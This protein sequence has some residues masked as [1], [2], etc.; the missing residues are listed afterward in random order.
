MIARLNRDLVLKRVSLE[1]CLRR[2]PTHSHASRR[3][4]LPETLLYILLLRRDE[5]ARDDVVLLEG[6]AWLARLLMECIHAILFARFVGV[7]FF[8]TIAQI[9]E[10]GR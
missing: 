3:H 9:Y 7:G 2:Y 5:R 10:F 8:F 4:Q 6:R 1:L